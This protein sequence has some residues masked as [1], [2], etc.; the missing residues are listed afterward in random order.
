MQKIKSIAINAWILRNKNI[1]GIGNFTIQTTMQLSILNP[2]YKFYVLTDWNYSDI[3]FEKYNNI[4]IVKI[5]PPWRHPLLYL[6][7]LEM[8][9]PLFLV[10]NKINL[11]I[12]MDGMISMLSSK[13][14]ISVIHDLNFVHY[15]KFLPLKNR[16]FYNIF[17]PIYARKAKYI[18]TVSEFSKNDITQC[19]NINPNKIVV[20]Y[21]ASKDTFHPISDYIKN[22]TRE[23]HSSGYPYFITL[24]TIHPRKNIE[25][26]IRAFGLFL[27]K[28]KLQ[29][30]L[31]LVGQFMWDNSKVFETIKELKLEK[32]VIITGRL[33]DKETNDL[34]AS[35]EALLFMS[36]FE[37]FGIPI[38]EAFATETPVICSNT[39][40][41]DEISGN[42]ALKADPDNPEEISNKMYDL[43]KN[44]LL[45][46]T[47]KFDGVDRNKYFN[48]RKTAINLNKI[49]ENQHEISSS[50][51]SILP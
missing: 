20:V 42:A 14:Q 6:F 51:N 50:S 46:K 9:L 26:T 31:I 35:A 17:Y 48:W 12:G 30:K 29:Y 3:Y 7:F 34:L 36:Y 15:P 40:S 37:G 18:A 32:D 11:F 16:L 5:F 33:N 41:L 13:N 39:T 45:R 1:D 44:E 21:C 4:K 25:N 47:L 24:G 10:I 38:L 43:I 19:F 49:I 23:K 22:Q 2:K 28:T 8:I 27:A